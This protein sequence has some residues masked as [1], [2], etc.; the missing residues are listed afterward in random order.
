MQHA[1][2]AAAVIANLLAK[3]GVRIDAYRSLC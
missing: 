2:R 3:A 1:G